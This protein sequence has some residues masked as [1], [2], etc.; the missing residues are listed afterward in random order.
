MAKFQ[1][2]ILVGFS[3][4]LFSE[5]PR[6]LIWS[7]TK[8]VIAFHFVIF[9]CLL[10][11]YARYLSIQRIKF[12]SDEKKGEQTKKT[13]RSFFFLGRNRKLIDHCFNYI[14]INSR[15]AVSLC[16]PL[17]LLMMIAIIIKRK[18]TDDHLVWFTK[19]IFD[20][21]HS[22]SSIRSILIIIIIIVIIHLD[23]WPFLKFFSLWHKIS[24]EMAS[25]F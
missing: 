13:L 12:I 23:N 9:F 17:T 16:A 6:H 7:H 15:L 22:E 4:F 14:S 2:K 25:N 18:K 1:N 20:Y 24:I 11:L 21:W 8:Q 3:L 19:K 5:S 10:V